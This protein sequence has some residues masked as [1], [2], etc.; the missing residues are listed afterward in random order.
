M[1]HAPSVRYPVGRSLGYGLLLLG[2]A[3]LVLLIWGVAVMHHGLSGP[4]A[5]AGG[6][7]CVL[8]A[9]FALVSWRRMPVGELHWDAHAPQPG[10]ADGWAASGAWIWRSAAYPQGVPL[11]QAQVRWDGQCRLLLRLSQAA[12]AGWWVWAEQ[13]TDEPCWDAF[14]QA[15]IAGQRSMP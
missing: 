9:L 15:L 10:A 2:I 7:L 12:G 11:R 6:L 13:Q 8:W 4:R 1:R 14:R 3:G 5:V